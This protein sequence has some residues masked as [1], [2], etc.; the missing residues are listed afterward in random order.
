MAKKK[1][2]KRSLR[3]QASMDS[4]KAVKK[5]PH[6]Y[7]LLGAD[8]PH[9]RGFDKRYTKQ[10]K[11]LAAAK[12]KGHAAAQKTRGKRQAGRYLKRKASRPGL[13][14]GRKAKVNQDY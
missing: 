2:A 10:P 5:T 9:L 1:K 8:E 4:V 14:A 13:T 12:K 11:D 3:V 6:E 7:K